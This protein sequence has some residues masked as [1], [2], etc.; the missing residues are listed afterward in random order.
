VEQRFGSVS[1]ET[2]V[3]RGQWRQQGQS[4]RDELVRIFVDVEDTSAHREFFIAFKEKLKGRFQQL[5][6]WMTTYPIEVI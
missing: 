5:D 4:Y 3:I 6:V 2:Q 1:A